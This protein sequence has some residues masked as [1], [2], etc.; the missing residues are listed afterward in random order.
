MGGLAGSGLLRLLLE[1]GGRTAEES[2]ALLL[3]R[4]RAGGSDD[5]RRRPIDGHPG[6]EAID[7]FAVDGLVLEQRLYLVGDYNI[8]GLED[9]YITGLCAANRILSSL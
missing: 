9:S 4:L 1:H 8:G 5:A 7:V 2:R 3:H 6:E